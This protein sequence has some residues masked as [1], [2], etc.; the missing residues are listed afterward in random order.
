MGNC[1]AHDDKDGFVNA[2]S[3]TLFGG[4]RTKRKSRRRRP[5]RKSRRRRPKRKSRRRTKRKS[6][7]RRRR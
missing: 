4:R 5:K 1:S 6:R 2:A 3:M 7:R